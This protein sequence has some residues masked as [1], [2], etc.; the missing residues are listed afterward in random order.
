MA[1]ST[2]QTFTK[3]L[4]T[5]L[6]V[7]DLEHCPLAVMVE[8]LTE[9]ADGETQT[10][11]YVIP[12]AR[13]EAAIESGDPIEYLTRRADYDVSLPDNAGYD[14]I[15]KDL[16]K[17]AH[18]DIY[19]SWVYESKDWPSLTERAKDPDY[20]PMF[21][22]GWDHTIWNIVGTQIHAPVEVEVWGSYHDVH[23]VKEH[24]AED[25]RVL[26]AEIQRTPYYN[27]DIVGAES[28]V[29]VVNLPQEDLDRLSEQCNDGKPL[30]G[31]RI[32]ELLGRSYEGAKGD[33]LGIDQFKRPERERY[34][35]DEDSGEY[36]DY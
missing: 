4:T 34:E 30:H 25:P 18:S 14:L 7:T 21:L 6:E 12:R 13:M 32:A 23:K 17:L 10:S 20:V 5:T 33:L 26:H 27:V 31:G 24:V 36:E 11:E 22:S 2:T 16:L 29:M 19:H 35:D 28:L 8:Q 9:L 15:P 1:A 3:T